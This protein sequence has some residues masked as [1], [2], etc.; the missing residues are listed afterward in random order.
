MIYHL[1]RGMSHPLT[2]EREYLFSAPTNTT[3]TDRSSDTLIV[4]ADTDFATLMRVAEGMSYNHEQFDIC[5]RGRN[6]QRGFE[7]VNM[8]IQRERAGSIHHNYS[9]IEYNTRK[10]PQ[11]QWVIVSAKPQADTSEDPDSPRS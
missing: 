1:Y 11:L 9:T 4:T 6:V 2:I 3:M 5:A 10:G 7:I 8:L